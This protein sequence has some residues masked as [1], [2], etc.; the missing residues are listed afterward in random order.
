MLF[1]TSA[2]NSSMIVDIHSGIFN[3]FPVN[4]SELRELGEGG[5]EDF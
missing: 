3:E 5:P 4:D 2:S 1:I